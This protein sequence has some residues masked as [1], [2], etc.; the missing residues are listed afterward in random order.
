MVVRGSLTKPETYIVNAKAIFEASEKDFK[1]ESRDIVYV[2]HRP[3]IRAEELL[4]E[5]TQSFI[6]G[7]VTAFSGVKI[8]P[9]IKNPIF[10]D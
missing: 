10:G 4:D 7:F 5:A 8:G 6:Q 3:W 2:A 9:F 1:L